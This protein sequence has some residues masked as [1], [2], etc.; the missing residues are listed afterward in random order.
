MNEYYDAWSANHQYLITAN[1]DM[2][3]LT[4]AVMP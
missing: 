1:N 4:A 3:L 2:N